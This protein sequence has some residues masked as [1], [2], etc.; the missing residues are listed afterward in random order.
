MSLQ[1]LIGTQLSKCVHRGGSI[2][3]FH[4]SNA[5]CQVACSWR[6]L[7]DRFIIISSADHKQKYG[8]PDLINS[9]EAVH[10]TLQ[11][12][13]VKE[14]VFI[15]RTLDLS[16]IFENDLEL[17]FL[18]VAQ[19]YEAWEIKFSD[20]EHYIVSGYGELVSFSGNS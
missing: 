17:Q 6:L 15:E 14:V 20:G 9:A 3:E 10:E 11:G 19:G 8:R 16:I 1:N 18:R 7:N 12:L 13:T 4:F 2:W 5:I